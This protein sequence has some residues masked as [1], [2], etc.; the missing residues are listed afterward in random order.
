MSSFIKP[1]TE[2]FARVLLTVIVLLNAVIP[3]V[4]LAKPPVADVP[5]SADATTESWVTTEPA[6][7]IYEPTTAIS[8]PSR[9]SAD[10]DE[11]KPRTPEKD[12]IEFSIATD[13]GEVKNNRTVTVNVAIRNN[14]DAVITDLTYYDALEKGLEYGS[15]SDKTVKHSILNGTVTYKVKELKAGEEIVFSYVLNIKNKKAGKLSIHNAEIEYSFN[16]ETRAQTASLGFADGSSLVDSDALIVVPDKKGDGWESAG[17]YSLYL[18]EEVLPQEA[19]VSITP[20]EIAGDGPELQFNLELIQTTVPSTA[21]GGDLKEQD[22]NLS[23]VVETDFE[24]PAYLEIN[25]DGVADL[26][27]VPADMEPYVATYDEESNVWVKVP[28]VETDPASNSVTVEAAHFSTWGAGLGNSLPKNGANVLLF[29]Q[30]YT[31]LFTG[32]SRY[33]IPVWTPPGRAGVAPDISLSYS[34]ATVDGVLGDVQAPWVGVGWNIDGIEIVRKITTNENGYGYVNSFALTLNGTVYELLVDPNNPNRYYTKQ[35][36]FLYIE[37]HNPALGNADGVANKT[38]EWW[39]VVTTDGT[40]YRLG[41]NIDSEQLALMYGYSCTTGNPCTTPNGAYA[42]LGYAGKAKDLV[43]LRWRVDR[44]T[45]T[46]GNTI[47]YAYDE[48][49]PNGSTTLA[50]FDRESYIQTISYTG[51]DD[52]NGSADLD[53]GYQVEFVKA[54]RSGIG[55]VPATFN[56]W[57]NLDS[58]YLDKIVVKCVLCNSADPIVIRTYD[59]NYSLAT[60]PNANGTLKL[61]NIKISGGNFTEA[62]QFIPDINAPTIKFTYQNM[63]NRS[64]ADKYPYPRLI[65]INNGTGGLLTYTYETDGRGSDSWYNYRVKE[66]RVENGLGTAA[67][68]SY[69]YTTPV[70]TGSGGNPNLGELIGYTTTSEKQLDYNNGNAVLLETKHDFGTVGLDTGYEL[71]TEWL[72][73]ATV[74][75]KTTNTYVTDN[76]KAPFSGWNYRYLYQSI[77]Y[78]NS[79]G[80]LIVASKVVYNRDPSTG[81]LLLQTDYLGTSTYRKTYYEYLTNPNPSVYILDKASRVLVVKANNAVLTDTRYHYDDLISTAPTRGDLTLTQSLTGSG[82]QTVDTRAH[83]DVYGNVDES[84]VYENYGTVN[85]SPAGD[86]RTSSVVYDATYRTYPTQQTNPLGESVQT[87]YLYSLGTPYQVTDANNWVTTTTY[88]GLGR[89][90]SITVPGVEDE[91]VWYAYPTPNGSGVIPAPYAVEMQILDTTADKY[92]SVWGIYDGL[93]RQIQMQ[94]FDDDIDQILVA[95]TT[96]NAQGAVS[97]QSA[98]YYKNVSGGYYTTPSGTQFT[99]TLYDAL[100]R[101]TQVTQPGNLI[102]TTSYNGLITTTMNPNGQKTERGTDGLGRL[103]TIREYSDSSTVYATTRYFNDELNRLIQ[104]TDAQSNI[105]TLSYDWLGRKTS[106]DDPDMGVWTYV[107]HPTGTLAQQTDARNQ[108]LSFTYDDLNRLLTKTGSGLSVS[109]GY[110]NTPGNY[111]LRTSM[112]DASGAAAWTYTNFG[113]TVS[114]ARTIAGEV[115]T[116]TTSTDWLGRPLTVEY[117]D[118]ET[119]SYTYDALGRPDQLQTDTGTQTSLVNL[120]YNVLGQVTSQALGNGVTVTNTYSSSTNRL[121]SRTATNASSTLINFAYTYDPLGNIKSITDSVLN[122]THQYSYDFLNR[123]TSANGYTTGNSSD[124]KYNQQFTYDKVGNITLLNDWTSSMAALDSAPSYASM[125]APVS[126]RPPQWGES[127]SGSQGSFLAAPMLQ[128][129]DTPTPTETPTET[130]TPSDTPSNTPTHTPT[131]TPVPTNTGMPSQTS[132]PSMTPTPWSG[133]DAYTVS[134]LHMNGTDASTTF[135]DQTGK[136]WTANGNSQMDTAQSKFD[137]ASVLFDGTDDYLTGVDHADFDFPAD[138]TI[139]FWFRLNTTGI[140]Q[141]LYDARP[142]GVNGMYPVVYVNSNNTLRFHANSADRITGTTALSSGTWYHGALVRSG[143]NTKLFLNG[144]QEGPTYSDSNSYINGASRPTIGGNGNSPANYEL[145]GWMDELRISK[146][147]ARWTSNFTPPAAPY[148]DGPAPTV[149]P[150]SIPSST[151]V[152]SATPTVPTLNQSLMAYW[153]FE[154]VTGTTVNDEATGDATNNSAALTNGPVIQPSGAQGSSVFF[155]GS[156]DYANIPDQTEIKKDGSFT[157]SAWVNPASVVTGRTQYIVQKGGTNKDY[158]LITVSTAGTATPTPAAGLPSPIIANG[159]VAFQV[160]D[161]TPNTLY[162]PILPVNTWTMVTGVYDSAA[163]QMRLYLNGEL[164]ASQAVTGTVSMSTS[165]LT[166]S[167]SSTSNVYQGSL[168]EVRFYNRALTN[169]EVTSV[170]GTF[171][172]PTPLPVSPTPTVVTATPNITPI[173]L[174]QQPW[175]TGNDGDLTV[176]SGSTFNINTQTNGNNGR[177]CADAVAYSVIQLGDT[178]ATLNAAPVA[179]CLQPGDEVMLIQLTNTSW[180]NYNAGSYEFLRV[181]SINGSTVNFTTNKTRWYGDSWRG[182]TNIGTGAGQLKVMLIRVPNYASVTV[183]GVLSGNAWDGA[184]Y[185]L[186][187][188]R[189]SGSLSGTGQIS[190]NGLGFRGETWGGVYVGEGYG[191]GKDGTSGQYCMHVPGGGGG[192]G[193]NGYTSTMS[194]GGQGGSSYGNP[195]LTQLFYGSGGGAAGWSNDTPNENC[196]NGANGGGIIFIAGSTINFTGSISSNSSGTM[197]SG[198]PGSGGSVRIEGSNILNLNTIAL[199]NGTDG[200]GRIAVYYQSS[201]SG[202]TSNPSALTAIL[203]Q[204]PTATPTATPISYEDNTKFGSGKDGNLVV[205]SGATFNGSVNGS[206]GRSCADMVTYSVTQINETNLSLSTT[207]PSSCLAPGDEILLLHLDGGGANM[208]QYEFLLVGG[209]VGNTIY[210]GKPKVNWYGSNAGSDASL[211]NVVIVRVPNYQ[212]VTVNGTLKSNLLVFRIKG[213]LTGTGS[214]NAN[215]LG[216]A[217]YTGYGKGGAGGTTSQGSQSGGGGGY[218]TAGANGA[219]SRGGVGGISYGVLNLNTL[220]YGSGGG[221][222]GDGD[223]GGPGGGVVFL[224]GQTINFQGTISSNGSNIGWGG[225]GA[226]GSVRIEGNAITANSVTVNGGGGGAAGGYGRIAVYYQTFLTSSLTSNSYTYL[227]QTNFSA[228]PTPTAQPSETPENPGTVGL[229]SWWTM[230][231]ASGAR[232]D[233]HGTNHLTDNNTVASAAGIKGNA[234]SFVT[235][236]QEYLSIADNASIS[237]G[238]IDFTIVANVYLNSTGTSFAIVNKADNVDQYDYRLVFIANSGFRLRVGPSTASVTVTSDPVLANTWYTVIAWHDSV[239]DTINIQVN[240]GPVKST[241][242]VGGTMDTV[243]PLTVGAYSGGGS[244]LD[245]RIDEVALYKRVLTSGERAWLYNNGA[246]RTYTEVNP[247]AGTNPGTTNLIGWWTMDEASGTR[248]DS[249]ST[250]HLTSNNSVGSIAGLKNTA[251]VFTTATPVQSLSIADNAALSTGDIDFTLS[252]DVYLNSATTTQIIAVKGDPANQYTR[253]YTLYYDAPSGKFGFKVGNGTTGANVLSTDSVTAGQWYILTAWHD[254][255]AN[256]INLQV[257]NG[258]VSS[259]SYSSGAMNTTFALSIGAHTNGTSALD[260]RIDEVVIYKRILTAAE[261]TW[262]YNNGAGRAYADLTASQASW[263]AKTYTYSETI[264]H[265]VTS[266]TT[267]TETL[268]AYEYDANGN[269][270][271]RVEDGV[272]YKQEYNIENRISAIHKMTGTCASGTIAESWFFAY[273]GDGVRVSTMHSSGGTPD[274]STR[275]YFGGAYETRGD[276]A[277][278]KYY[279]FSG[280]TIV[281]VYDPQAANWTLSYL[282]TDHLGSVVAITDDSGTLTTQQRYLPFG[283]V[284]ELSGYSTTGRTDYTYTGQRTL[285]PG[286]GGLMDYKARFYSPYL[287]RFIQPDTLIPDPLNPQA[288]NRFSYVANRPLNFN[289]PTGH[290]FCDSDGDSFDTCKV[291]E[292]NKRIELSKYGVKLQ[293]GWDDDHIEAVLAGIELVASKFAATRGNGESPYASFRSIFSNGLTFGWGGIGAVGD[294]ADVTAG[295]CTSSSR[296]INFWSMSGDNK[297]QMYRR[298]KNVVHELGHA[299]DNSLYNPNTRKRAS[300]NMPDVFVGNRF[301][302]LRPNIDRA[303]GELCNKCFDW[304]QNRTLSR[305]ETF[306][307]MFLAWTYGAWNQDPMNAVLVTDA[308]TWM[309]GIVP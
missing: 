196:G 123:L 22:I 155:D 303:S 227:Q 264:P 217:P 172:T 134:M 85:V 119:L 125:L 16:G 126:Y 109:Y 79:G 42:T 69:T 48:E 41:W 240:N 277:I 31:S 105:T 179:G 176:N 102:T 55:D 201:L 74:L 118:D 233:S 267:S 140:I 263:Q 76:T 92:R 162:G 88:D 45:D 115:K 214:I 204:S 253:D 113:R 266:L 150:T 58:Q 138:F 67:L 293:G 257:N 53:A 198:G 230:N 153:S 19:V 206:N 299:Y 232:N 212:D 275:Y 117:P 131:K 280:Q 111:G 108:A 66:V 205:A 157:I 170:F 83:Y 130:A 194:R 107:Y 220:F 84:I 133:V 4:A 167:S 160:G 137:G 285:D 54:S 151:P 290:K 249:H 243:H 51:F 112:S 148:G 270:T 1:G 25:L 35:G 129:E 32:A 246:G 273:D 29:D 49:Q 260:G 86:S 252:A 234:A 26:T 175:G 36:S 152:P 97:S 33:S 56:V 104:V 75:R 279:S 258:S 272:T 269:M 18:A 184:K 14:S 110:G 65:K 47:T 247:P 286:M 288:W 189:A 168:D 91:A 178:A 43:A 81:N 6:A 73:G 295:G 13:S 37:R 17:R 23:K 52:P 142:N 156:N 183:N 139:D 145:N 185:G 164:V 239:T 215:G 182:D 238:N 181:A 308:Q 197:A 169:A 63:D 120:T 46:H 265:A 132:I 147:I 94:V 159:A 187:A 27:D 103:T 262:L 100:G 15:S 21:T 93:G 219:G 154:G 40:R 127:A 12:P 163:G 77:N 306:A 173:P 244:G 218:G 268:G 237:T 5:A 28:I 289:D 186:I 135:A 72:S 7:V 213:N 8:N 302:I 281:N 229:V 193:T 261:R 278:F 177:T 226:G 57:D 50:A 149:T 221:P 71:K 245:G 292:T 236:N 136:V 200:M 228:T 158:G 82:N 95:D 143:T 222:A 235:A 195:T 89:Q 297:D 174:S 60:V 304:Q 192:Y 274:T 161:L 188:F 122:E 208:G 171:A 250:N 294:C 166:F 231:E 44:I 254:S 298:I 68:R 190:S 30:P 3:T 291:I 300:D 203:G 59:L 216:F 64:V 141:T 121:A 259:V 61:D 309:N 114:E 284:R 224:I 202:L 39:E 225:G 106:M 70:Y 116:M 282:L 191:S 99:N 2:V 210:F 165:P 38:G 199:S 24:A 9:F 80:S 62:G 255:V 301:L 283:G 90:L 242:F 251:A 34:S 128:V 96:F 271:C 146:G 101:V 276:G 180:T 207:P 124:V 248:N 144:I 10:E 211:G 78:I 87:Q 287:N 209:V 296:Q 305:G 241:S 256:T 20:T 223:S 98:P 11:E 307:D